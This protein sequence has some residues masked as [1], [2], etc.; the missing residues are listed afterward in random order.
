MKN[1]YVLLLRP[2]HWVKNLFVFA[3][4]FFGHK[5]GDVGLLWQTLLTFAAFS[6]TASGVYVFND[7]WDANEDRR[8]PVKMSRP[9]ASGDITPQTA[10]A[11]SAVFLAGGVALS[12]ISGGMV[13]QFVL[14][15][16]LLNIAYTI[17]LKHIPLLDV[18]VVSA[19]FVIRLLAG[20]AATG[21][22]LSVWIIITTF[23]LSLFLALA[24]RR[25]DILLF[26]KNGQVTRKAMDGYNLD[27]LNVAMGTMATVVMIAYLMYTVSP[28]VT[29]RLHSG[30]LYLTAFFVLLGILRYMQIEFVEGNGGNPTS[31][32]FKDRFLQAVIAG[33]VLAFAWI[34]YG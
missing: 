29:G 25:E 12:A 11:I 1:K 13:W 3:P 26:Q 15:Y 7:I 8:H 4:L 2:H 27:F 16:A 23:L 28:D 32:L 6:M 17:R 18:S 14:F 33:W 21:V 34:L 10:Y 5:F 20:S 22:P 9:I 19:G 24:K 30:N 31:V